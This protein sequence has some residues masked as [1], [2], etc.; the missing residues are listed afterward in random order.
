MI[1]K[2]F[3]AELQPPL[4]LPADLRASSLVVAGKRL[5]P[6]PTRR[7]ESPIPC[8]RTPTLCW[9]CRG[10][11]SLRGFS[12]T[13]STEQ[14]GVARATLQMHCHYAATRAA[15]LKPIPRA[16]Q[17][18]SPALRSF[19]CHPAQG[20]NA[21]ECP[22]LLGGLREVHFRGTWQLSREKSTGLAWF[23]KPIC[24]QQAHVRAIG[25]LRW[26]ICSSLPLSVGFSLP[27]VAPPLPLPAVS[28]PDS[29]A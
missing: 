20:D 28:K 8:S 9:S 1:M 17:Q 11:P 18:L 24:A 2:H 12:P 15:H 25:N 14:G 29:F 13:R 4:S 23:G 16:P 5:S 26:Q 7:M 3:V 10:P 27:S 21:P 19:C 22:V 6:P